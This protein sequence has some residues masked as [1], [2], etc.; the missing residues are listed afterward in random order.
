M[1]ELDSVELTAP[2]AGERSWPAGTKGTIVIDH[3][4]A[5]TV[6]ICGA[7]GG[8]LDMVVVPVDQLRLIEAAPP[9]R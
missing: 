9:D 4:D 8:M 3:G 7:S 1:A 6:E 5:A 2:V